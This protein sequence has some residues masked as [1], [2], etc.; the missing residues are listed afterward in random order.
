[1]APVKKPKPI[2]G[3]HHLKAWR[4]FR[5][6]N[7]EDAAQA[8]NVERGTL[9]K[10]E[11]AKVPYQQQYVE[12][13]A[14]LYQ[15]SPSDLIGADPNSVPQDSRAK[16][17]SALLAYGVDSTDLNQVVDIIDTFALAERSEETPSP[18]ETRPSTRRR[19]KEPS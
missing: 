2:L 15:C 14:R 3:A 12:G 4:D 13:L 16:L 19:A 8:I 11:N 6:V 9:S 1:M 7:Q 17:R 5:G 18:A 10:I